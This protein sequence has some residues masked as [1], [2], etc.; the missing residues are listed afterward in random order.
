MFRLNRLVLHQIDHRAVELVPLL[1]IDE[2]L[3][4]A[5]VEQRFFSIRPGLIH[6]RK[7]IWSL[8]RPGETL[9]R[10]ARLPIEVRNIRH[11][12]ERRFTHSNEV[13]FQNCG[14]IVAY[15]KRVVSHQFDKFGQTVG[16]T[17]LGVSG[18]REMPDGT[19]GIGLVKIPIADGIDA[20]FCADPGQ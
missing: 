7:V 9:L 14:V 13:A 16:K 20:E 5:Q 1:R 17:I 4:F 3:V 12:N 8:K 18:D 6:I 10:Y 2:T 15:D 11:R 19:P